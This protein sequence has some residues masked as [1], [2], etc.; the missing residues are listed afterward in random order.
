MVIGDTRID[1]GVTYEWNGTSWNPV[2]DQG[3]PTNPT[4]LGDAPWHWMLL[5]M[6]VYGGAKV[7]KSK[8]QRI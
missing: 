5:L 4:P 2:G 7:W 6:A 8:K 1:R 3:D